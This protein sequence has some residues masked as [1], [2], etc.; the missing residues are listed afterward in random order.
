MKIDLNTMDRNSGKTIKQKKPSVTGQ[1][2]TKNASK[3]ACSRTTD[4]VL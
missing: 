4:S 2:M 1:R 3:A